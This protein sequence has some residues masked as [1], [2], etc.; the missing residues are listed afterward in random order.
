MGDNGP[1]GSDLAAMV[2]V[3][4]D[5]LTAYDLHGAELA[6]DP[7]G[8]V[9]GP[10]PYDNLVYVD[11]DGSTY[12]QTNVT[13]AGRPFHVR[14]F[15]ADVADGILAFRQ[16]GPD[17]PRHIG[18]SGGPGLIWFISADITSPG[19]A[20]YAE[21]DLIR[22][23]RDER[24]RITMLYRHGVAVRPMH[25]HGR[26]V[27]DDPTAIHELDPRYGDRA[28][29]HGPRSSTEHYRAHPTEESS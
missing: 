2:G 12:R 10:F 26:R 22:I 23:D 27:G 17:A 24:W 4:H 11:F 9:P 14:S 28:G 15:E 19:L 7:H 3:W 13:F 8:G 21:P 5:H 6:D 16:L 18:V 1:L 20:R 29:P 25:V